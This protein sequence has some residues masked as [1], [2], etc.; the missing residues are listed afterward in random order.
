MYSPSDQ[1][2]PM[3][4]L[5]VLGLRDAKV[6]SKEELWMGKEADGCQGSPFVSSMK[7]MLISATNQTQAIVTTLTTSGAYER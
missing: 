7:N 2:T 6:I 3:L 4:R 5:E 1:N